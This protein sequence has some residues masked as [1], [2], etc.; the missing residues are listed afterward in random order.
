MLAVRHF[1]SFYAWQEGSHLWLL[2][3]TMDY[4]DQEGSVP[5]RKEELHLVGQ[6]Q[7]QQ[8][9]NIH[10]VA[11]G[12][13]LI[14]NWNS[15]RCGLRMTYRNWYIGMRNIGTSIGFMLCPLGVTGLKPKLDGYNAITS[16]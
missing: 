1:D 12:N 13:E 7:E 15:I 8:K 10:K 11:P 4:P 5:E 14:T 3:T 6:S 16:Y 9:Q 2:L